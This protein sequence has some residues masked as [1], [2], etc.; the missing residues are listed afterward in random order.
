VKNAR[1]LGVYFERSDVMKKQADDLLLE[2]KLK[3]SPTPAA[4][5]V[6]ILMAS[7]TVM[8]MI[9]ANLAATKIWSFGPIPVDGGLLL[10]PLSY[11]LGDLLMEIY[12]KRM[13]DAVAIASCFVGLLTIAVIYLVGRL[14]DYPGADNRGFVVIAGATGRVFFAS[15]MGCIASQLINNFVFEVVRVR[16]KIDSFVCPA[17]I[18]SAIAHVPDTMLFEPIAFW[19]KL[20]LWEFLSQAVFAYVVAVGVEVVLLMAITKR[21]AR[22]LVR[23]LRFR[24]GKRME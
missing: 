11:I 18:S 17:L 19:G 4:V 5:V 10:F 23:R 13:A 7:L 8:V 15:V 9:V 6:L 1:R 20:S 2:V 24:H 3:N 22:Y 12:G 14:P 16:Q 21:L